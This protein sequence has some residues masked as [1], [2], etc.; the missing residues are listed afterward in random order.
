MLNGFYPDEYIDSAYL[1]DFKKKYEEGYR[2]IIF[3]IDNTLVEHGAPA[4][5]RAIGLFD[6]LRKMGFSTCLISNN[7][8]DRVKPFA[9][10]VGSAYVFKANKPMSTN[11]IKAME[12]MDTDKKSTFFVG[13]QIFTDIFGAKR[14]GIR[15]VLVKQ[16][17]KKEE[18]QIVLKRYLE[19]IVLFFYLKKCRKIGGKENESNSNDRRISG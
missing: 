15:S 1:I 8:E 18:I 2:G 19:K 5:Q 3:D 12:I 14:T 16:I 10:T 6:S 9:E 17:S 7:S 11:Y 13:D 4:T